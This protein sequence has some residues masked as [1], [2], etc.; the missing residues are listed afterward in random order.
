[1][2]T[3]LEIRDHEMA[4]MVAERTAS[5]VH[6]QDPQIVAAIAAKREWL[7]GHADLDQVELAVVAHGLYANWAVEM[8][9]IAISAWPAGQVRRQVAAM[10]GQIEAAMAADLVVRNGIADED[11]GERRQAAYVT[12]WREFTEWFATLS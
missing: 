12:A 8:A 5:L 7:R 2:L 4:L 9:T 3:E 11:W 1:M 10:A 6:L